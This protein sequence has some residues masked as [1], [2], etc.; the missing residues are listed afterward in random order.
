VPAPPPGP[1]RSDYRRPGLVPATRGSFWRTQAEVPPATDRTSRPEASSILAATR[2]RCPLAQMTW[3]TL[4]RGNSDPR[5]ATCRS[6]MDFEPATWPRAYSNG[7]LT[8]I[9]T[10]PALCAAAKSTILIWGTLGARRKR[11]IPMWVF[12]MQPPGPSGTR[13]ACRRQRFCRTDPRAAQMEFREKRSGVE[14]D[15]RG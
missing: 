8:S 3:M 14:N 13:R 9:T 6:G 2:L 11:K 15:R 7:S 10:Q 5:W 12:Y 1:Q 4:S